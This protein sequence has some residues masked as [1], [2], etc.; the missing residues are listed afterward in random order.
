[1]NFKMELKNESS[2]QT[3]TKIQQ[4]KNIHSNKEKEIMAELRD[5]SHFNQ[6]FQELIG[7]ITYFGE[8]IHNTTFN[9]DQNRTMP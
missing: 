5:I 8:N 7:N 4:I 1:M 6:T 2:H 9:E 3:E